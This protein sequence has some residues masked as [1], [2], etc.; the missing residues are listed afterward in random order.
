MLDMIIMKNA[1]DPVT[2]YSSLEKLMNYGLIAIFIFQTI[3]CLLSA[4]FRGVFY[5]HNNL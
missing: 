5:D 4:I 3:L 2:K 1:K